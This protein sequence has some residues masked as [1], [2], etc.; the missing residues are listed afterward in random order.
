MLCLD[1]GPDIQARR[2]HQRIRR[3]Q[4]NEYDESLRADRE[5]EAQRALVVANAEEVEAHAAKEVERSRVEAER[6]RAEARHR[7]EPPPLHQSAG[8][9]KIALRLPGGKRLERSFFADAAIEQMYHF[10]DAEDIA[11]IVG[12]HYHVVGAMPR[13]VYSD[14]AA[15]FEAQ[16][17]VGQSSLLIEMIEEAGDVEV[18]G[19][20]HHEQQAPPPWKWLPSVGTWFLPPELARPIEFEKLTVVALKKLLK[21]K[22]M[23]QGGNKAE[24]VRRLREGAIPSQLADGDAGKRQAKRPRPDHNFPR[25][26]ASALAPGDGSAASARKSRKVFL[27]ED[28]STPQGGWH[29]DVLEELARTSQVTEKSVIEY[30]AHSET[31]R[32]S[33]NRHMLAEA[34]ATRDT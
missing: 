7:L 27:V 25:K 16:G 11:E 31:L 30:H 20:S 2:E 33:K 15:T 19:P 17:L 28:A 14:R 22:G 3:E 6:K 4:D 34:K 18:V 8:V 21:E 13:K 26:R 32:R 9:A 24:L 1:A 23:G 29:K 5:K 12:K 10:V